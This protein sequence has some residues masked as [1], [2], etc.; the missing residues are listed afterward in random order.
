MVCYADLC[1]EKFTTHGLN[2]VALLRPLDLHRFLT[3]FEY[4]WKETVFER[5]IQ[6]KSTD[7]LIVNWHC[8][9]FFD[10]PSVRGHELFIKVS[11]WWECSECSRLV[12]APTLVNFS[13]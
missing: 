1:D 7:P 6:L 9:V 12:Y 2:Y 11:E 10:I 13:Y 4:W 5:R 3:N 8:V